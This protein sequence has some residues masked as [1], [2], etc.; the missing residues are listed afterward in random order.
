M[1][2]QAANIFS[3][4]CILY[5]ISRS[6]FRYHFKSV[7]EIFREYFLPLLMFMYIILDRV[8]TS[9]YLLFGATCLNSGP[10]FTKR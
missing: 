3:F 6:M 8:L 2:L 7:L 5:L 10:L 9:I 4:I 1:Y